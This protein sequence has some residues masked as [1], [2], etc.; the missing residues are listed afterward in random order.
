LQNLK[1]VVHI[2]VNICLDIRTW[3]QQFKTNS[4]YIVNAI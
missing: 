1:K 3:V 2:Y 4:I